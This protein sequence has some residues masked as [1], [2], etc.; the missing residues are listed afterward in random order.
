VTCGYLFLGGFALVLTGCAFPYYPPAAPG[1]YPLEPTLAD[2][3]AQPAAISVPH[4][5]ASRD[6]QQIRPSAAGREHHGTGEQM[7]ARRSDREHG[8]DKTNGWINPKP[9]SGS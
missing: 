7:Q 2:Y 5:T 1:Y 8:A 4:T 9:L 3:P 6:R